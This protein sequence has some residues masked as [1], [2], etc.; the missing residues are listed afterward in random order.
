MFSLGFGEVLVIGVVALLVI[1][2]KQLPEVAKV[3]GRL[4]GE[5]KRAT[6]D[7]S[8]GLLSASKEVRE[9]WQEAQDEVSNLGSEVSASTKSKEEFENSQDS[10]E[11]TPVDEG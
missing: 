9:T 7:L 6:E 8:G 1:G 5:F 4:F 10:S 11:E 2:P 3:V